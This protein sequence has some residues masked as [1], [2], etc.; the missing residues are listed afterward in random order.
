MPLSSD[1]RLL[2]V[3]LAE[4]RAPVVGTNG[5]GLEDQGVVVRRVKDLIAI[6]R[7]SVHVAVPEHVNGVANPLGLFD[8][9][10][11]E[12]RGADAAKLGAFRSVGGGGVHT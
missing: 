4:G 10:L 8:Q 12:V 3:D 1:R 6:D 5:D 9:I 2:P 11:D 7:A